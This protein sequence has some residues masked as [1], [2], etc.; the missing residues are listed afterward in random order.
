MVGPLA[1]T[2]GL[3]LLGAGGIFLLSFLFSRLDIKR[4]HVRIL[5]AIP[6]IAIIVLASILVFEGGRASRISLS[7]L[8]PSLLVESAVEM[9]WDAAL[10]PLG[11]SLSI[12]VGSLILAAQGRGDQRFHLVAVLLLSLATGL[13]ALWSA[14]P[15]TTI[16]CWAFYDA[17]LVLGQIS[18]GGSAQDA[19]RSLALG[20]GAGLCLW[21]GILVAGGGIGSVPWALMPP[22]GAKMT[23]W[24]L[25]GLLRLGAYPLH[26]FFPRHIHSTSPLAAVSLL[27]PVLGWGLWIRL[28]LVSGQALPVGTWMVIPALLTLLGGAVLGWTANSSEESRSWVSIGANGAVLLATVLASSWDE[29]PGAGGPVV[30]TMT[31]GAAGWMLGTTMLFLGDG[32]ELEQGLRSH[33]LLRS[34]PLFIGALSLIGVPGTVGFAGESALLRELGRADRW[35]LGLGFSIGHV[36]LVATVLRWLFTSDVANP[37]GDSLLGKVVYGVALVSLAV[38]LVVGGIV[39]NRLLGGTTSSSVP[40]LKSLLAAP[41]LIGW[42]LWGASLLLGG[43]VAWLDAN[44]RPRISLWLDALHDVLSLEWAY[45]L[46][47]GA[48]EQGF[49]LL[50]VVDEVLGGRGA[51][52]WSCIILLVLI[53]MG[54]D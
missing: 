44:L 21:A 31:L 28:A 6:A 26:L 5:M 53:L 19:V 41:G 8:Y 3:P 2:V 36:F 49:G 50:R 7:S 37:S 46:L 23:I 27:S 54:G 15:L 13:A 24:M 9:R 48:V 1:L 32:F 29:S 33:T 17:I 39:P 16:V 25:A 40:S 4:W 30:S 22:G 12:S 45:E 10:W 34:I 14:N 38:P 43:I 11:L 51:L 52:L 42:L 47:T 35:A 20:T 18:S